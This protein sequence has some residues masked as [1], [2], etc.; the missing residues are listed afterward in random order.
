M[1]K[2]FFSF[3]L[4]FS[5]QNL[6]YAVTIDDN[7]GITWNCSNKI[8]IKESLLNLLGKNQLLDLV[9]L[10]ENSNSINARLKKTYTVDSTL[11]IRLNPI[12][13]ISNENISK[14]IGN[15]FF[16]KNVV[17]KK[18]I[19]VAL[20]HPGRLTE[21]N[22]PQAC[23]PNS[24]EKL[25]DI[26]QSIVFWVTGLS[27]GWPDGQSAEWNTN[28]WSSGSPNSLDTKFIKDSFDDL[29]INQEKYKIGCYTATKANIIQ[30][31]ISSYS[32]FED[33]EI[34]NFYS[35]LLSDNDPF[36]NIEPNGMWYFEEDFKDLPNNNFGKILQIQPNVSIYN[37]IPGDWVYIRNTDT[38]TQNKIGYEGS[39]SIYLGSGLF[40]DYYND[41]EGGYPYDRKL[42]EVY[43]WRNG[44]FSRTR[45]QDKIEKISEIQR[46]KLSLSPNEGGLVE[47]YRI[48][49]IIF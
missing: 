48:V 16:T 2:Y 6:V 8:K 34:R 40:S 13:N 19:L 5:F 43:Q 32:K 33:S 42:D 22:G 28:Y 37:F 41:H 12:F 26:R 15:Q 49:P 9:E 24:L 4:F 3:V 47:K 36:V 35:S 10:T 7:Y 14:R 39:N 45:D 25:L 38:N 30:G 1:Y 23:D 17:S 44:V 18:E 29:Y 11:Y 46:F 31:Y 20:L 27:W 21:F